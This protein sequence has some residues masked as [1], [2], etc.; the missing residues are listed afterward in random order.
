MEWNVLFV[1]FDR[2]TL[3]SNFHIIH[4]LIECNISQVF[5]KAKSD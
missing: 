5:L 3:F 4:Y 2:G 1:F